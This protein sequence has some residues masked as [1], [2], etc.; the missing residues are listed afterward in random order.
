MNVS[1]DVKLD[2]SQHTLSRPEPGKATVYFFQGTES[3][4]WANQRKQHT[5][6]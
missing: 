6:A 1:F 3:E 2:K 5:T 4:S